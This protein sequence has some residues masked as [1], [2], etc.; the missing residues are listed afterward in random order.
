MNDAVAT[1]RDPTFDGAVALE[2]RER[3]AAISENVITKHSMVSRVTALL[4]ARGCDPGKLHAERKA[5]AEWFV[6]C[7]SASTDQLLE[8]AA[9]LREAIRFSRDTGDTIYYK[10]R[11]LHLEIVNEFL[12]D[13]LVEGGA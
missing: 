11:S 4:N 1:H 6:E 10:T 2:R 7:E 9:Y 5:I 8:N 13:G 3:Q 12:P